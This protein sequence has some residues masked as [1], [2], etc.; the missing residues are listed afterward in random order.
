MACKMV[1]ATSFSKGDRTNSVSPLRLA[2]EVKHYRVRGSFAFVFVVDQHL[3]LIP[4]MD[5]F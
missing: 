4:F 2:L 5:A 3:R 1:V